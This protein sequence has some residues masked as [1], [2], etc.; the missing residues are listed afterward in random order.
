MHCW[1]SVAPPVEYLPGEQ[2]AQSLALPEL[3]VSFALNLPLGHFPHTP[4]VIT[5][6]KP[7]QRRQAGVASARP[8]DPLGQRY[9]LPHATELV[10]KAHN[11]CDA[12]GLLPGPESPQHVVPPLQVLVQVWVVYATVMLEL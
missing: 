6:G 3:V 1:H 8:S 10:P 12:S 4:C 2:G 7:P 5:V 11:G 9:R